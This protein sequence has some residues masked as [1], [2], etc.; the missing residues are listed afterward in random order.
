MLFR[1]LAVGDTFDFVK[2]DSLR[3]SFY[4]RCTKVSPR[5]YTYNADATKAHVGTIKVEVYN[6]KRAP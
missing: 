3:N 1:E 4:L 5:C 2:P 6:V